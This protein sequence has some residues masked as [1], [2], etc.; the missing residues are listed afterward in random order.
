MKVGDLVKL[1]PEFYPREENHV[2]VLI[3]KRAAKRWNGKSTYKWVVMIKDR[4]HPY[5]IEQEDME[6]V[7]ESR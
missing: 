3:E 7:D 5:Y 1:N 4:I 6:L 2:G